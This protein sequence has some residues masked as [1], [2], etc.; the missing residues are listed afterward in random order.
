VPLPMIIRD[1][2]DDLLRRWKSRL[3]ETGYNIGI[4]WSGGS[5]QNENTFR[6]GRLEDFLRL[7][8]I[9]GINL[10]SLQLHEEMEAMPENFHQLGTEIRDFADTA[11]IIQ[12]LDLVISVDT[13]LAH[14][15]LTM[16]RETWV[17]LPMATDWRWVSY[18]MDGSFSRNPD[19][20]QGCIWYPEARMFKQKTRLDRQDVMNQ[21]GQALNECLAS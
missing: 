12:Q 7:L 3:S 8:D 1:I 9:P 20:S 21:V 5:M 18:A 16:R 13:A 17:I 2:S 6:P 11:A 19:T 15:A 14:L 4:A 10:Y